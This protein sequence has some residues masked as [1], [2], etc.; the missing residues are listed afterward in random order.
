MVCAQV[1]GNHA[2]ITFGGCQGHF[3]LN[4][5]KPVMVANLLS[6]ARLLG[7]AS[8]L[9][10]VVRLGIAANRKRITQ[11][12]ES[13]LMLVTALNPHIGYDKASAAK[14]QGG[15]P[16]SRRAGSRASA[17]TPPRSSRNG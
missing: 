4:V 5:F 7:D 15:R 6:S 17:S 3:E 2:A 9:R 11:L 8:A 10:K 13:S 12:M 1:V 14:A 16:S